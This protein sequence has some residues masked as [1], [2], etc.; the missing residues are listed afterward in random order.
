MDLVNLIYRYVNRLITLDDLLIKIKEIDL[1][2]YKE[3]D[4][5]EIN[6][7]IDELKKNR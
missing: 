3:D 5:L 1:E 2:K 6:K 7:L 4:K